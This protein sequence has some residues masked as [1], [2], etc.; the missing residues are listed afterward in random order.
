MSSEH[1]QD[2][3]VPCPQAP[4]TALG[5]SG[6][7]PS[8]GMTGGAWMTP[9]EA[10]AQNNRFHQEISELLPWYVN[11]R[12]DSRERE[13]VETHLSAVPHVKQSS[14]SAGTS[15]PPTRRPG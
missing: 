7:A 1:R 10:H 13:D 5:R 2:P 8:T 11:G 15:P 12:L 9:H 4:R 14:N 3:D 6:A